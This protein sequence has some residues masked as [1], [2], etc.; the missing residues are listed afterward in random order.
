VRLTTVV[1]F[2]RCSLLLLLLAGMSKP[3]LVG[4][5]QTVGEWSTLSYTMPINPIHVALLHNGKILVVAG[6]GNCPSTLPGCPS[7]SPYGPA[8][9]SGALRREVLM[10][11]L[12]VVRLPPRLRKPSRQK[13]VKGLQFLQPPVLPRPHFTQVSSEFHKAGVPLGLRTSLPGQDLVDLGQNE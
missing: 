9:N 4:Q 5:V 7:G 11:R 13:L 3:G 12:E 10:D 2:R 6:S 8:N 1:V